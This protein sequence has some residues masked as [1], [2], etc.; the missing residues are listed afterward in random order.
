M[1]FRWGWDPQLRR[2]RVL[3]L[4]KERSKGPYSFGN[5]NRRWLRMPFSLL[6]LL[7]RGEEG[8]GNQ[9]H[10]RQP[11]N[12]G[13]IGGQLAGTSLSEGLWPLLCCWFT[14]APLLR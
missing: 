3:R 14:I 1:K 8:N 4:A 6:A 10:G 2:H 5:H 12:Q 7:K 9:W 11:R 13:C